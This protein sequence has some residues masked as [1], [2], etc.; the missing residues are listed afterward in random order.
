[1]SKRSRSALN[2]GFELA[3]R[4]LNYVLHSE[5]G[6]EMY[7]S[8]VRS[9]LRDLFGTN[10]ALLLKSKYTPA[11]LLTTV[12]YPIVD[13][14]VVDDEG[15]EGIV[16]DVSSLYNI[17]VKYPNGGHGLYCLMPDCAECTKDKLRIYKKEETL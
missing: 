14:K 11:N 9:L 16:T 7:P 3:E 8:Q 13:M 2:P 4:V 6:Q 1:M 15:T 17:L 12:N 10:I 5:H